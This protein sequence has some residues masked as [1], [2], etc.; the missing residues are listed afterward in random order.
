MGKNLNEL[1]EM[2]DPT[3]EC[4]EAVVVP[5]SDLLST[6]VFF[7]TVFKLIFNYAYEVPNRHCAHMETTVKGPAVGHIYIIN[8]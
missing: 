3:Q 4:T 6:V 2:L 7:I 1:C 5:V 8:Y